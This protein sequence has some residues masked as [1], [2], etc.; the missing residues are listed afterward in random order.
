MR[1]LLLIAG[2]VVTSAAQPALSHVGEHNVTFPV[3][4]TLPCSVLCSYNPPASELG[5][6]AC[7]NPFPDRTW[8]DVVT[9]A[10]PTPPAGRKMLLQFEAFPQIDWDTWIC[11]LLSSGSHNGGQ[12]A[13]GSPFLGENCDNFLGPDNP[14]PFGCEEHASAPAEAGKRYVIRGYNFYDP[15][16]LPGIY[17]W[18]FV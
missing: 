17:R 2:L 1:R 14:V 15:A 18:V 10:A 16:D 3:A 4:E 8:Y 13:Q 12:I 9:E 5:F 7:E 11:A 6:S